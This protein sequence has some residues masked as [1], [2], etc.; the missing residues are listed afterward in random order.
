MSKK[1]NSKF[2]T[3]IIAGILVGITVLGTM[4]TL[5]YVLIAR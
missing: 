2:W 1:R 4:G 3:R 5:L